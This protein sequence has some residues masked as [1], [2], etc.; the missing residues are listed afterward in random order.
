MHGLNAVNIGELYVEGVRELRVGGWRVRGVLS[1]MWVRHHGPRCILSEHARHQ[2]RP[3]RGHCR[4]GF[5][6]RDQAGDGGGMY[7]ASVSTVLLHDDR[8]VKLQ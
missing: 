4:C 3:K 1:N 2:Q 5:V 8:M 7:E 6:H